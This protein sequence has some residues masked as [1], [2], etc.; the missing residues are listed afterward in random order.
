MSQKKCGWGDSGLESGRNTERR[1]K[2]KSSPASAMRGLGIG[3]W[4]P[5]LLRPFPWT[6]AQAMA[7]GYF[8]VVYMG[9]RGTSD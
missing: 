8:V 4:L 2:T 6:L 5:G 1:G 9:L 3:L 7:T